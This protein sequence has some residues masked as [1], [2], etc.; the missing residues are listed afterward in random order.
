[1]QRIRP[2]AR[3]I[4]Q[5]GEICLIGP[6]WRVWA[7]ATGRAS[8]GLLVPRRLPAFELPPRDRF[9]QGI[10]PADCCRPLPIQLRRHDIERAE[11]GDDVGEHVSFDQL[12]HQ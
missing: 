9:V 4:Q 7:T 1:M 8:P 5:F 3:Y 11:D 12:C 6:A 10:A 2:L